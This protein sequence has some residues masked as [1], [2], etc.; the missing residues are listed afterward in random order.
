MGLLVLL[1]VLPVVLLVLLVV[2]LVVL[3]VLLKLLLLV[4]LVAL[5]R[6]PLLLGVPPPAHPPSLLLVGYRL[7]G[8][9]VVGSRLRLGERFGDAWQ[10]FGACA[11]TA[12]GSAT[13][14]VLPVE[15]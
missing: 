8:N 13:K 2:L 4:L 5:V 7:P 15:L 6:V 10:V 3:V 11:S 9:P 14:A 12:A 1:V